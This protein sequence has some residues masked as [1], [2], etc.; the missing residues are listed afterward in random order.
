[1]HSFCLFPDRFTVVLSNSVYWS[2]ANMSPINAQGTRC[3]SCRQVLL[4]LSR[5]LPKFTSRAARPVAAAA[6]PLLPYIIFT[7]RRM[8]G[9]RFVTSSNAIRGT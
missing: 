5:T 8:S 3:H 2:A 9:L 7:R 1:M 4:A 6:E